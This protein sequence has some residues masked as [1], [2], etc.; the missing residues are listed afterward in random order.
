MVG[1]LV[2][3]AQGGF[4]IWFIF[5][6]GNYKYL[7]RCSYLDTD[8][9]SKAPIAATTPETRNTDINPMAESRDNQLLYL[10]KEAQWK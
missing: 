9:R 4:R 1:R 7:K 2:V 5:K 8:R 6:D 3:C 10:L